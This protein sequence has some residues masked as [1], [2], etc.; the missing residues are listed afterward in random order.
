MANYWIK[1][2]HE[3]IDDPKM[4]LLPDR[5]WRRI[6]ELFLL[7]GKHG[8]EGILPDTRQIA[9]ELRMPL[10]ELEL[11]MRQIASTGIISKI[12]GGWKVNN[13]AKRQAAST[14]AERK[15]AQR[16]R[17]RARQY[18]GESHE[19]VT[20]R[21]GHCETEYRLTDNRLTDTDSKQTTTTTTSSG[22]S[23]YDAEYSVLARHYERN[24]GPLT[25][26][27]SEQIGDDLKEYGLTCCMDA[28]GEA[29]RQ[30][31]RK[32]S[33]VQGVLKGMARDGRTPV[34]RNGKVQPE[35]AMAV[36]LP[37]YGEEA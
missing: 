22:G 9:W 13:F 33:Y 12:E 29:A 37:N 16:D 35:E 21:D 18:S 28:I 15:R 34:K 24:I 10:D 8:K 1:L 2:Y 20:K 36:I 25:P 3:I 19:P 32:W 23:G 14:D 30:N 31:V 7:G 5:L 6:I 27:I 26:I 17:E 11:D 4:A